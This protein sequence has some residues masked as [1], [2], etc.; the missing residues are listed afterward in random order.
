MTR[1]VQALA[2]PPFYTTYVQPPDANSPTPPEIQNSPKFYPFFNHALGAID[3][4]HIHLVSSLTELYESRVLSQNC[5][6]AC[7]FD[8]C[9][10]F[11]F[12]GWEDSTACSTL[13]FDAFPIDFPVPG[14]RYYLAD[15]GFTSSEKLLVPYQNVLYHLFEWDQAKEV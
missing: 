5:V 6:A 12:S 8:L 7:S 15:A 10:T 4:T 13:F 3:G 2:T 11:F 9:F 14:G 1:I